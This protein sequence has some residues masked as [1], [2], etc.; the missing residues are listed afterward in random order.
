MA[1]KR[2]D[3]FWM[4]LPRHVGS[5]IIHGLRPVIVVSNDVA[6][7]YSSIVCVVPVTKQ[8]KKALPTHVLIDGYGLPGASTVLIEQVLTVD[9]EKLLEKIGTIAKTV[10]MLEI[11]RGIRIQLGV[12]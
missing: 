2:G 3:I 7:H 12:A 4:E 9:K 1:I 8:N 5:R 6:N 10:K 11:E